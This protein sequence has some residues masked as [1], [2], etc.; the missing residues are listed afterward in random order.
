MPL[1]PL[2]PYT[3]YNT[4]I[5][6]YLCQT[7]AT[8]IRDSILRT[9]HNYSLKIYS[10]VDA[11]FNKFESPWGEWEKYDTIYVYYD[12]YGAGTGFMLFFSRE[13]GEGGVKNFVGAF[14]ESKIALEGAVETVVEE[15]R[16]RVG[17]VLERGKNEEKGRSWHKVA[18]QQVEAQDALLRQKIEGLEGEMEYG[19]ELGDEESDEEAKNIA[20]GMRKTG[21]IKKGKVFNERG[22]GWE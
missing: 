8:R 18:W 7:P 22:L 5:Q 10:L 12:I 20:E 17:N 16:V 9:L 14:V 13:A 1:P 2:L 21:M 3:T 4:P 6:T 15:G 11:Q 19:L